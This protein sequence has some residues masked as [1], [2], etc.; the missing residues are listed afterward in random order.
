MVQVA[1]SWRALQVPSTSPPLLLPLLPLLLPLLLLPVAL[2][3]VLLLPLPLLLLVL[4][5]L[6]S[7]AG[8]FTPAI[9]TSAPAESAAVQFFQ[10]FFLIV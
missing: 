5:V 1:T 8:A 4:L 6:P 7:D 2:P 10:F 3:L 9:D